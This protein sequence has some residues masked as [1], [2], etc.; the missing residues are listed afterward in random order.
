MS[1]E[2]SNYLQAY[3][4]G[5]L[6]PDYRQ[7][8]AQHLPICAQCEQELR[9]LQNLSSALR[10]APR[11]TMSI[12]ARKHLEQAWWAQRDRGVLRLAEALTGIAAAVLV[13]AIFS[14]SDNEAPRIET[15]QQP[16]VWQAVALMPPAETRD[17]PSSEVVALAQWIADDL[18]PE[19]G[20]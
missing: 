14:W 2:F 20:R 12:E 5:Q 19:A 9:N 1:C 18:S 11:A 15:A 17:E 3:H 8:I 6:G 10:S 4:D 13:G 16:V 7:I